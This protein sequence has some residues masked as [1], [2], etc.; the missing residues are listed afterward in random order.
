MISAVVLIEAEPA[1]IAR[2]AEQLVDIERVSEVY[3]VTGEFDLVVMLRVSEHEELAEVVTGKIA[4]LEGIRSTHSMVAFRTYRDRGLRLGLRLSVSVGVFGANWLGRYP[5]RS[6]R[7]P[8]SSCG[9]A[10]RVDPVS[11]S[12]L[13]QSGPLTAPVSGLPSIASGDELRLP[14]PRKGCR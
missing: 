10:F 6:D 12:C 11:E 9:D 1:S 7:N 8:G 5:R 3:S 4:Q 2:L 14:A 13:L